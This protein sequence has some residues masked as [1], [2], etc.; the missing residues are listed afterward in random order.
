MIAIS[1]EIVYYFVHIYIGL[2]LK[3]FCTHLTSL[4]C[5]S[6]NSWT[7]VI[8]GMVA[9]LICLDSAIEKACISSNQIL[10]EN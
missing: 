8:H 2:R 5:S 1:G 6:L 3:C 10:R 4:F 9:L 7:V